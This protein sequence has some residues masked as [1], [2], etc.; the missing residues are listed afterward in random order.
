MIRSGP[1]NRDRRRLSGWSLNVVNEYGIRLPGSDA[2]PK[3][4]LF[5]SSMTSQWMKS[6]TKLMVYQMCSSTTWLDLTVV[7]LPEQLINGVGK[8]WT[9]AGIAHFHAITVGEASPFVDILSDYSTDPA[10]G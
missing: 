3:I 10:M 6:L 8:P 7:M 5:N 9:L 1:Y 4:L 2:P